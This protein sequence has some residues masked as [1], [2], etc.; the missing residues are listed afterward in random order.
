MRKNEKPVVVFIS[1]ILTSVFPIVLITLSFFYKPEILKLIIYI[2]L[3]LALAGNIPLIL[4]SIR[5]NAEYKFLAET[6]LNASNGDL[7]A[8]MQR[9][10]NKGA[11]GILTEFEKFIKYLDDVFSKVGHSAE[12]VKHLVNTVKATSKEAVR[13]GK[14]NSRI[15]RTGIKRGN[16]TGE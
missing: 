5:M 3:F 6:L 12:E 7:L 10:K 1:H 2:S 8:A 16:R 4:I 11:K 9:N 13:S 15:S 14:P